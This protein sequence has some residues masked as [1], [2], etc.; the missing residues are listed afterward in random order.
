M[1]DATTRR[2]PRNRTGSVK[3]VLWW[4]TGAVL[5]ALIAVAVGWTG[6]GDWRPFCDAFEWCTMPTTG[7]TASDLPREPE[8]PTPKPPADTARATYVPT[9]VEEQRALALTEDSAG[10]T[11]ASQSF[12]SGRSDARTCLA[13]GNRVVDPCFLVSDDRVS[14]P[15]T[16]D[17]LVGTDLL[18]FQSRVERFL[19]VNWWDSQYGIES[20]ESNASPWMLLLDWQGQDGEPYACRPPVLRTASYENMTFECATDNA[21]TPFLATEDWPLDDDSFIAIADLRSVTASDLDRTTTPWTVLV[22]DS[23]GNLTSRVDVAFAWF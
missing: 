15:N 4:V 5:T 6:I 13:P 17:V 23:T 19:P 22:H 11:C 18:S 7:P 2:S 3:R 1:P 9:A 12:S 14:C 20:A 21:F 10:I 8:P 16:I